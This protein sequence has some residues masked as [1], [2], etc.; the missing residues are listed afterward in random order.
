MN[1]F[2]GY[3]S[4]RGAPIVPCLSFDLKVN[5]CGALNFLAITRFLRRAPVCYA[6]SSLAASEFKQTPDVSYEPDSK[7]TSGTFSVAPDDAVQ[8]RVA[9]ASATVTSADK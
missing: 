7:T 4:R 8:P 3:N 2:G 1:S 5:F 9:L 6:F